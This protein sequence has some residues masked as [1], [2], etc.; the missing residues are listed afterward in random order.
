MFYCSILA[1]V[2]LRYF[3]QAAV[4][5]DLREVLGIQYEVH[6]LHQEAIEIHQEAIEILTHARQKGAA[7]VVSVANTY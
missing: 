5:Q 3:H 2:A 7:E 1:V 4:V 6:G